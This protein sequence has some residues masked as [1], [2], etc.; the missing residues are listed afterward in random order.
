MWKKIKKFI[1]PVFGVIVAIFTTIFASRRKANRR[2]IQRANDAHTRIQSKREE[3]ERNNTNFA[4]RA[5]ELAGEAK[6]DLKES[7]AGL[8]RAK[9]I[10]EKAKKRAKSR[11]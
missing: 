1:A 7:S 5:E 4:N 2:R 10:L 9:Q 3:S 11:D 8:S 6:S